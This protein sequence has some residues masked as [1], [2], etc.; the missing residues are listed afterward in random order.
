MEKK[1]SPKP[2]NAIG[3]WR[4]SCHI[5]PES[6]QLANAADRRRFPMSSP[7]RTKHT[8]RQ[9]HLWLIALLGVIVPRRLRGDWRHEWHAEL[10]NREALLAD[11]HKLNLKAKF[12]LFRRSLG[13]FRDALVLQPQRL[14]DELVQDLR[15]GGRMLLKNPGFAVVAVLTLALGI[16]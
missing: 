12:D 10:Q 13:A 7:D 15:Y 2:S 1:P 3:C 14:E 6:R 5:H 4:A 16:G 8:F 11:W 9:P